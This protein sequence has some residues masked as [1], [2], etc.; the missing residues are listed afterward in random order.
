MQFIMTKFILATS[1][2]A[3]DKS[4]DEQFSNGFHKEGSGEHH[5]EITETVEVMKVEELPKKV[6]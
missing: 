5:D 1:K 3:H 6:G 2:V 4:M